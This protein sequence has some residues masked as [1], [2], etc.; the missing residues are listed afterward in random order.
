MVARAICLLPTILTLACSASTSK[1]SANAPLATT[2]AAAVAT[3]ECYS[4]RYS[5][6]V[7]GAS[8]GLFPVWVMLLPGPAAGSAVGRHHPQMRDQDWASLWNSGWK[9]LPSDSLEIMLSGNYEGIRIHAARTATNL[10]GRATWLTDVI[11]PPEAS[12]VLAGD[13]EQCPQNAAPNGY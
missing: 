13:R 3:P 4:L 11:G 8:A 6:P 10:S 5:D 9:R 12:M 2:A 7:G 1:V